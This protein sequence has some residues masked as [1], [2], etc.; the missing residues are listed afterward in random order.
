M[1]LFKNFAMGS[2]SLQFRAELYNAF[3]TTQ[4]QDV[5]TGAV[6]D[7]N[8]ASRPTRLSAGSAVSGPNSNRI[9]QLGLRF[10]FSSGDRLPHGAAAS[11]QA[12]APWFFEGPPNRKGRAGE[13]RGGGEG[14]SGYGGRGRRR[15]GD[16]R[17][18]R[19]GM[20]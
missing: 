9:I 10:R 6:F 15:G 3:N 8:T 1:T 4:Y 13:G 14:R 12:A 2:R 18:G 16:R 7:Y 19:G 20:R 11:S 5:N 17:M